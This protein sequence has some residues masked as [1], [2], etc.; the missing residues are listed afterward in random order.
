MTSARPVRRLALIFA[1]A[2][3]G[4]IGKGG[5]LPW[6]YPE[7]AA[8]FLATTRG[9]AVI[10]GRRT[11]E[12]R[13]V[14]LPERTN[15]VVSR[16]FEA[17]AGKPE[18]RVARSLDAALAIAWAVDDEPFVIGGVRLFEEAM[19]RATRLY[20]TEIPGMPEGDTAFVFD[21]AGFRVERERVSER[22]LRFVVL[23]PRS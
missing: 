13:G 9:H 17:P 20:V 19:P 7:D 6:N 10:M 21:R 14:A 16:S 5:K 4:V 18:V 22:G 15:I 12:E 1:I 3:N 11:W 23:V 8:F 2:E